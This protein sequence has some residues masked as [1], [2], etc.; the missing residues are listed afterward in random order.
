VADAQSRQ[1]AGAVNKSLMQKLF[2]IIKIITIILLNTCLLIQLLEYASRFFMTEWSSPWQDRVKTWTY[3]EQ[4]GWA[5]RS[6]TETELVHP[7]FTIQV[8]TNSYGLRDREYPIERNEKKR[9]LILGDS[10]T[11]GYGVEAEQ[12]FSDLLEQ[13]LENWEVINAGISGYGTDQQY[14]YYLQQGRDFQADVVLLLMYNNDYENNLYDEQYNYNKPVFK[15]KEG[16]LVL[17][18]VPVPEPTLAQRWNR[19]VYQESYLLP[20]IA[21]AIN[22]ISHALF[23]RQG[24]VLGFFGYGPSYEVTTALVGA[25]NSEV[26]SDGAKFVVASY[27]FGEQLQFWLTEQSQKESFVYLPLDPYFGENEAEYTLPEDSHW[28]TRGHSMA[29]EAIEQGL[30][31]QALLP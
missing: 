3:D 15:V 25:L 12:R 20:K 28:N 23:P 22:L 9:M 26:Q 2:K 13:G 7:H 21:G 30:R 4:L 11:W 31:E 10:F 24:P 6:N 27:N 1:P 29:A 17:Q 5:Q 14:L 8:K 19:F 16:E 18:N